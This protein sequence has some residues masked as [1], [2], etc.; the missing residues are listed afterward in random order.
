MKKA[1]KIIVHFYLHQDICDLVIQRSVLC[2][3][4]SNYF[5]KMPTEF[6]VLSFTREVF[7]TEKSIIKK[8]PVLKDG[9]YYPRIAES[10]IKEVFIDFK[11]EN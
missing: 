4:E 11:I 7:E 9:T 6:D 1:F 5:E 8:H 3:R 2:T 10:W